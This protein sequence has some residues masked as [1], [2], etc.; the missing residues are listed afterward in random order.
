MGARPSGP[1]PQEAET[2]PLHASRHTARSSSP[3]SEAASST[4]RLLYLGFVGVVAAGIVAVFFGT[5]F[6]LLASSA[7]GR[8][9]ESTR[10]A[11]EAIVP[12][13]AAGDHRPALPPQSTDAVQG[14]AL[15]P[16][17]GG[18]PAAPADDPVPKRVQARISAPVPQGGRSTPIAPPS[19]A[20]PSNSAPAPARSPDAAAEIRELLEHGDALLRTGDVVS[21]R[22][23]YERAANA[24]DGRAALRLAAT[25]DSA[26]LGRLGGKVQGDATLAR[27]WYSRALDGGAAEAKGPLNGLDVRQGK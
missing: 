9:S 21:A 19:G 16:E 1:A 2:L 24:G 13:P 6:S 20:S 14:F 5:G 12:L 18:D 7:G 17:P 27:T 25:F 11:A 10:N 8:F 15:L 22:L 26:F 3:A 4:G 23:F